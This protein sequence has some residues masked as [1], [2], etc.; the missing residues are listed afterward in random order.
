MCRDLAAPEAKSE[1]WTGRLEEHS[2]PHPLGGSDVC[3]DAGGLP[4]HLFIFLSPFL[5]IS[6]IFCL[7][8]AEFKL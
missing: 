1:S 8:S 4:S 7:Y 2:Q 6:F 3:L 5:F